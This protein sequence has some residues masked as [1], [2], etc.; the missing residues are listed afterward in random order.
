MMS[1]GAELKVA[2]KSDHAQPAWCIHLPPGRAPKRLDQI[3]QFKGFEGG[4]PLNTER[5]AVKPRAGIE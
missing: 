5:A 1:I 2:R 3:L 4:V